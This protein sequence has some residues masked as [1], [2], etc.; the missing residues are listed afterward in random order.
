[1]GIALRRFAPGQTPPGF[2]NHP[3]CLRHSGGGGAKRFDAEVDSDDWVTGGSHSGEQEDGRYHKPLLAG[4][5]IGY[6]L[7]AAGLQYVPHSM[8]IPCPTGCG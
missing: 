1:M 4:R 3:A 2:S 5:P 7:S 6:P 8:M